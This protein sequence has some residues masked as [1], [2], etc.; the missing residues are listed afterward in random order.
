MPRR[1]RHERE[2]R[3]GGGGGEEE[4]KPTRESCYS[5]CRR[6]PPDPPSYCIRPGSFY[7]LISSASIL[8]QSIYSNLSGQTMESSLDQHRP[9]LETP[10]SRSPVI[11]PRLQTRSISISPPSIPSIGVVCHSQLEHSFPR[12][13]A[14]VPS[15]ADPMISVAP[16]FTPVYST[17]HDHVPFL[18]TVAT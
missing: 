18:F 6:I 16:E 10:S 13:G 1:V 8:R 3:G 11:T 14:I 9:R 4:G 15:Q 5:H 2:W 7:G 17:V 12:Q